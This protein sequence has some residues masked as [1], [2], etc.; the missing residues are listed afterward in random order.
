[1][2]MSEVKPLWVVD[3]ATGCWNW[4]R[5][6]GSHGYGEVR[7][8]GRLW[9]AHRL[10]WAITNNTNVETSDDICHTCDNRRCVNPA[11][12]FKGTRLENMRD[13]SRK[14]RLTKKLTKDQVLIIR[15]RVA[16]GERRYKV[17]KEFGV[18][19]ALIG[20]I[21]AGEVWANA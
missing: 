13:A 12:L 21:A 3:E 19:G 1:M 18:S 9:T 15:E 17:A 16:K 11:H 4:Q 6:S 7:L 8:D 20:K 2:H 5:P 14:W 10:M